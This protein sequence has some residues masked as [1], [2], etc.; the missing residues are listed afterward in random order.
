MRENLGGISV[1]RTPL[2]AS[3]DASTT[4]RMINYLSFMVSSAPAVWSGWR[5]DVIYVYNLVTLGA[6]AALNKLIRRIPY[7]LDVQ[8]LWPD[9]IFS[10]GMGF[11][12]MRR[13]VTL[14]CRLAYRNAS[15]LVVLSPGFKQELARRNVAEKKIEVIYNWYDAESN[16]LERNGSL[17]DPEPSMTDRFNILY[18]GNFGAAQGLKAVVDAAALTSR[19]HPKIQWVFLG[20]GIQEQQLRAHASAVAPQSAVFLPA[21]SRVEAM[22]LM[23]RAEVLLIHLRDDALFRITIPSK[24]QACLAVGK[25]ILAGVQ[26]DAAEL[27]VQAQAGVTCQP[28]SAERLANAAI[29]LAELP[30]ARLEEL[31]RNGAQ[32][33]RT[34]LAMMHGVDR[35]ER[36]L[37]DAAT[38]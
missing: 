10:S 13:P 4:R 30:A 2:Y 31:G 33:Y 17:D 6:V 7:V 3:H 23:Q 25:P 26:G 18:A 34:K 11:S 5:P 24:T 29:G 8:D 16:I 15:R 28:G 22:K 1:L 38:K 12:A 36:V 35:L 20:T 32:F 21:R 14:L 37:H 9:S 27:V 19:T